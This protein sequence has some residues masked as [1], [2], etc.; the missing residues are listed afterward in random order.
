M[1]SVAK[2][3]PCI[4]KTGQ[5][6]FV[7]CAFPPPKFMDV[8]VTLLT[9]LHK[10]LLFCNNIFQHGLL[11]VLNP[12]HTIPKKFENGGLSKNASSVF[13]HT[14]RKLQTQQFMLLYPFMFEKNSNRESK[15]NRDYIVFEKAPFVFH[16]HQIENPGFWNTSA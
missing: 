15:D 2:F 8:T 7:K 14:A 4:T 6:V 3:F 16:P 5:M 10:S 1:E 13:F 12:V 9:M 11:Y